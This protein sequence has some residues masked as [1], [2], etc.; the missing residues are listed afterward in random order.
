MATAK[1]VMAA[2]ITVITMAAIGIGYSLGTMGSFFK[3]VATIVD[4]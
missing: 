2:D 1:I 4:N 3:Q